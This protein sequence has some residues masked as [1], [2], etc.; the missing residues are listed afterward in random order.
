M[1]RHEIENQIVASPTFDEILLG[2]INDVIRTN[3]SDH[4]H[5]PCAAYAGHICAEPLGDLYSER[6][7]ASRRTVNQDLLPRLNL[8][9]V[10]Q[11]L[12]CGES[13]HRYRTGLLKSHVIGL[14]DQ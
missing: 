10:A 1:V 9:L 7:H 12:Q 6:A 11:T 3:R 13:R 5:I 8:S 4:L 14:R 2:V